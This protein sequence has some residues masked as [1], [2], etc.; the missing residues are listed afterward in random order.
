MS[1]FAAPGLAL[2]LSLVGLFVCRLLDGPPREPALGFAVGCVVCH[3]IMLG[4]SLTG[5]GWG[6]LGWLIPPLVGLAASVPFTQEPLDTHADTG[7][8]AGDLVALVGVTGF[9]LATIAGWAT[10]PDFVY[11]WGSK[12][13]RFF[14]VGGIDWRFLADPANWRL[15]ADYPTLWNELLA[16]TALLQGHFEETQLLLWGPTLLALTLVAARAAL[17]AS[18]ARGARLQ[19]SLAL[20]AAGLS[21]FAARQ[22]MAGAADWMV[23]LGLLVASPALLAEV[24]SRAGDLR[25]GAGAA[26]A[27]S[28]KVEGVVAAGILVAAYLTR[29]E[30]QAAR[31]WRRSWLAALGPAAFVT[32]A[33]LLLNRWHGLRGITTFELPDLGRTSEILDAT[34]RVA[35]S[36]SWQGLPVLLLALPWLLVARRSRR[37]GLV[38]GAQLAFYALV[39]LAAATDPHFYVL[40]TLPR[41]LVNLIPIAF[42][43]LMSV[44]CAPAKQT[45][46]PKVGMP[47]EPHV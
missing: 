33:W 12:A 8:G 43:A 37:L 15:H 10:A 20:L 42:V 39:Y 1:L 22:Q 40:S 5:V 30:R 36:S 7:W 9:A 34:L 17:V 2:L 25:V 3:L 38:V 21:G 32:A 28:S 23:A 13:A 27:A 14:L 24:R 46:R 4:C 16:A 29:R 41:L 6:H 19:A 26:L 44:L 45:P 11:H 47:R 31:E 18:G 35:L